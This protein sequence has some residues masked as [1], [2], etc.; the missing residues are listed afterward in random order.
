MSHSPYQEFLLQADTAINNAQGVEPATADVSPLP[1]PTPVRLAQGL[2]RSIE[3][4]DAELSRFERLFSSDHCLVQ[5]AKDFS[6]VHSL[7]KGFFKEQPVKQVSLCDNLHSPLFDELGISHL[8]EDNKIQN[9]ID[10]P[11]QLFE[12][13]LMVAESG[14]LLFS[15]KSFD[16]VEQLHNSKPNIIIT[17]L[18]RVV[19]SM[20]HSEVY[21]QLKPSSAANHTFTLFGGSNH[22]KTILLIVDNQRTALLAHRQQRWALTCVRCGRCEAV[23][24]IDQMIGT[25]PYDNVFTG[26]VGRVVLPHLETPATYGHVVWNCTLCGRCETVCPLQLPLRDMIVAN[27]RE[28][29]QQEE[30]EPLQFDAFTKMRRYLTDRSR[31]NRSAWKKQNTLSKVLSNS[32]KEIILLPKFSDRTF[33]Q[34]VSRKK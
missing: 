3:N 12:A 17:T 34:T 21:S 7:L 13:D 22:C 29:L 28:L 2:R 9:I 27:R 1:S 6:E 19:N 24:P 20:S 16:Y 30:M 18:E 33:H 8:L 5:W 10:A 15:N 14:Q 11:V 25:A 4:L 26:P 23:C 31:L 32:L